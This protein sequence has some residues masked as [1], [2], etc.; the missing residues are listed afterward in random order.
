[1]ID[2]SERR[3][4][5][6]D[7]TKAN[8]DLLA[9]ALKGEYRLSVALSGEA[10]LRVVDK[11]PPDLILLDVV[12]PGLDGFEVC[13]RL[14]ENK[15][16]R[17]IPIMF[18]TALDEVSS[19]TQAFEMGGTDYVTKPFEMLEVKARVRSLLKAKAYN[20]AFREMV[21]SELR[22]ARNIQ[23]SALPRE[24]EPLAA[25]TGLEVHA[26]MEPAREVGGDLYDVLRLPGGRLF[27]VLGDVS[28]KG[29]PAAMF[30]MVTTA[31]LRVAARDGL[32]APAL[33]A[34]LN[35]QL[36]A[37]NPT[38][39]FVTLTCAAVDGAAGT[40]RYAIAGHTAPVLLT[41]GGQAR[42]LGGNLGTIAGVEPG[43][44][45]PSAAVELAPGD[46]FVLYSDGVTESFE[47]GGRA[48]G[49]SGLLAA[50]QGVRAASA[51]EV[52]ERLLAAVRAFAAGDEP[53]DDI[54]ILA[55]RRALP[56]PLDLL[57]RADPHAVVEATDRV[58]AWCTEAVIPEEA[59]HD[60]ALALEEVGINVAVHAL[61]R[62][63]GASFRVR[64]WREGGEALLEVRDPGEAF[65][66][67][68][69][70]PPVMAETHEDQLPGGLGIYLVKSLV[71]R[72]AWTREGEEN[73][74]TL[75]RALD[76]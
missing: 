33:L 69:A 18:L 53:S 76:G 30:M 14:R 49:E 64:L 45:F 39:M 5:I 8:I 59:A 15:A 47:P 55:L 26:V 19:K 66:P 11:T 7:D 25:G 16:T 12:M 9:S 4:L 31:L 6:V 28:G 48:F 20:D 67:L 63:P 3:I 50:L 40:V 72:A 65:N 21:A 13:R 23:S 17:D 29:I 10:A 44:A 37:D 58:R 27:A 34:R 22:I 60:L 61:Q 75:A 2:L 35:D 70:P 38:S 57:V 41:A 68:E 42:L 36:C 52:V 71:T 73:V 43:L 32:D 46:T 56:V 54:A 74:L 1:M 24:F 51:R 62:R